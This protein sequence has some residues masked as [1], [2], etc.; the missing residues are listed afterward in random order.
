MNVLVTG[1]NGQLGHDICEYLTSLGIDNV[2][3]DIGEFDICSM[4]EVVRAMEFIK[5]THVAHCAAYTAVDKAEQE[6]ELCERVN[7]DGTRNIA[8]ACADFKAEM[9]YFSTDYVFDGNSKDEPWEVDD[10]KG[11]LNVYGKT[12]LKGELAVIEELEK[13]Y[14]A[15]ISWV[16]GISGGNFVKTMLRLSQSR[17]EINVVNDQIGAPTYTQD[18]AK[19]SL[20]LLKSG[21]YGVYHTPNDGQCSWYDFAREIF[22]K[23]GVD[24]KLNPV[25]TQEYPTAAAR[26]K[27]SRL[28]K[29]SLDDAGFSHLPHYSDALDRFLVELNLK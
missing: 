18:V 6:Q 5:P 27:N 21:S 8:R 10:P 19:I 11:P 24:I 15:R 25:T 1:A 3:A 7:V 14:I 28:S 20:E 17:D 23:A 16:Y 13:Y 29:K 26:P 12:K 9:L 22:V 2:A 4:K